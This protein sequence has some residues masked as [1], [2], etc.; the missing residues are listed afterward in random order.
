M[1][2]KLTSLTIENYK[3]IKS[4]TFRLSD[5]TALV[6]YNN[7]GK[8][9]VLDA[10]YWLL[11]RSTLRKEDF[12]DPDQAVSVTG[13]IEGITPEV[14]E[15]IHKNHRTAIRPY[16]ANDQLFIQRRQGSPGGSTKDIELNVKQINE[17]GSEEWVSNPGGIDAAIQKLFPEPIHIKAMENAEEDVGKF[18][19]TTTIGKLIKEII[20]PIERKYSQDV[21]NAMEQVSAIF[22][23]DGAQ[24]AE[25]LADFD[26]AANEKLEALFPDVNIRLDIP[27][28]KVD[29]FFK[30]GTIKVYER[31]GEEGK[32][33][34]SMG[35]GA[36]RSIQMALIRQLAEAK[37]GE[38]DGPTRTLLL[39]DEPE[40]YLH[41][42]AIEQVR[43]ALKA[44]ANEGYQVL[45]STHSPIMVTQEDVHSAILVR[46]CEEKGTYCRKRMEDAVNDVIE[47]TP[48]Q[49]EMIFELGNSS[50]ILFSERVIL[51]EGKTERKVLPALF[52]AVTG[53]SFGYYKCALV[54]LD[55][56]GGVHKAMRVLK[57]MDMPVKAIVDLDFAFKNALHGGF[58]EESDE[59]LTACRNILEAFR[60]DGKVKLS[61]GLP[62]R[63]GVWKAPEAFANM[64]AHEAGADPVQNL[65]NKLKDQNIWLW[66]QGTI[67][68][69]CGLDGKDD[70]HWLYLA[71]QLA[72]EDYKSVLPH[73]QEVEQL[74]H[75]LID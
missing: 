31:Q 68:I 10:C 73:W 59:D 67:E 30:S 15:T 41:P 46:K 74:V 75:W 36:Q 11:R 37:Q 13:V 49:L 23:A 71:Q 63:K 66:K 47:E 65:H 17:D 19:T 18:K 35:T 5:Y 45:F 2:I 72:S 4:E 58:L 38:G 29:D 24:R 20:A 52:Q 43:A 69:P 39:I 42:Q 25:E 61:N 1:Q 22:G 56:A 40:L 48:K 6:G 64:A 53:Q 7:A 44:L 32:D 14:L 57:A 60:E 50:Q 16:I 33:I 70:A 8:S 28:P 55:G 62:T 12:N 9:N 21:A 51:A 27:T 26:R 54:V 3:S 34:R